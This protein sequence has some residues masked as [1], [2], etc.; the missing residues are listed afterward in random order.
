LTTVLYLDQSYS[1]KEDIYLVVTK[2]YYLLM[3][4]LGALV[5]TIW[6]I[7]SVAAESEE[8]GDDQLIEELIRASSIAEDDLSGFKRKM[9]FVV[10]EIVPFTPPC[11]E[12]NSE[13]CARRFLTEYD[14]VFSRNIYVRGALRYDS[15]LDITNK[16]KQKKLMQVRLKI[17]AILKGAKK[18]AKKI[19]IQEILS[20]HFTTI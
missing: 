16:V 8:L 3:R 1:C 10:H 17:T 14:A 19:S 20:H 11:Q 12:Y 13:S 18:E 15:R 6:L 2:T 7:S 5:L 4:Y 9:G